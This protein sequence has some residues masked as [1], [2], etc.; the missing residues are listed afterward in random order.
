MKPLNLHK[1][2]GLNEIDVCEG[3]KLRPLDQSD[4]KRILEI[5]AADPSI[6][7]KVSVASRLH[8]SEDVAMEIERI[9]KDAGLMRFTILR[10]NNP[11]GLVSFWR[12]AGIWDSKNY[13]NYG[14]GYF[15]DPK[16]RGK[17]LI[18]NAVQSLMN[19]AIKNLHVDLFVAFCEDH[20][21]ESI[22][23]LTKLGFKPTDETFLEPSNGWIER[24]YVKSPESPK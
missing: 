7:D 8:N 17:G 4:A 10:E 9:N 14:F 23:V 13:D 5:L 2:S 3:I 19:A 21:H 18:P 20:N 11:I 12:E 16:E 15:I 22:A 1:I 24:K 6:R